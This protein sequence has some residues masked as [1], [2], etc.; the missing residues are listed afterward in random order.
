MFNSFESFCSLVG[1]EKRI[2]TPFALSKEHKKNPIRTEWILRVDLS[3]VVATLTLKKGSND[4]AS[5]S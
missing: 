2:C 4:I 3:A 1:L 5:P